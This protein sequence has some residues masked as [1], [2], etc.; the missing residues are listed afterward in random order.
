MSHN[1]IKIQLLAIL[2]FVI[3]SLSLQAQA[4]K[5]YY[6]Y[7]YGKKKTAL[8]TA[9]KAIIVD[10]DAQSYDALW[11]HFRSTD[12]KGNNQVWD[13]YSEGNSKGYSFYY[14]GGDQCGNYKQE[15][16]C[17]NR[18]HS[19]PKSWF[20]EGRPMYTDLF[21]LYPTDGYVN[22]RRSNHPFGEVG[23]ASWT[24]S[25]GSKVGSS[26]FPGYNGTVFEPIDTYKG[27]FARSYFYMVTCYE[28]KVSGWNSDMLSG[29]KYPA[30]TSWALS[31]LLKWS[32]EDPVSEKEINRNNEVYKIQGNRNPFIDFPQLVEYV[33]GDSIDYAFDPETPP[34]SDY[35][36]D[37]S[38]PWNNMPTGF[39]S[40]STDY[41]DSNSALGFNERGK[42]LII[43]F[44]EEA[45]WLS[46]DMQARDTWN[47]NE[48]LLVFESPYSDEFD[49]PI[50]TYNRSFLTDNQVTNSGEIALH[51]NTRHIKF[52]Y[53][54]DEQSSENI[55][56]DNILIKRGEGLSIDTHRPEYIKPILYTLDKQL[57][58]ANSSSGT[59][60]R[61]YNLTGKLMAQNQANS[62][63]YSLLLGDDK[64]YIVVLTDICGNTF[65]YKIINR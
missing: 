45:S 48:Q 42:Y 21:H 61:V 2:L 49:E 5:G 7:A 58:I 8:K 59:T 32:R 17:Y 57:Y 28:D 40:N 31:L 23:S 65:S 16:D 9:L 20:S 43:S 19:F 13:M 37:F 53:L 15:G 60:I 55:S 3:S 47:G 64:I 26:N 25:N 6:D 10:H 46:F 44:S 39:E 30:F 51:G 41:Y 33:W 54:K 24:S 11:T 18:E 63:T 56:I 22:G 12:N 4:P 52:L 38:G 50:K 62:D 29:N 27:D 35:I 36:V 34:I 14:G 1:T